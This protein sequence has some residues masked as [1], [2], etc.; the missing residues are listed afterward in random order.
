MLPA[1]ARLLI[2]HAATRSERRDHD[3]LGFMPSALW[4][5]TAF[6][7]PT[8]FTLTIGFVSPSRAFRL[9]VQE[10]P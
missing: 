6:S 8:E 7:L 1:R 4:N 10:K 3:L 2:R 9:D 5:V